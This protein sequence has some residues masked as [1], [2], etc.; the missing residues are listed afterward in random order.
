MKQ[1]IIIFPVSQEEQSNMQATCFL[2]SHEMLS[3]RMLK[4][5][6]QKSPWLAVLEKRTLRNRRNHF[7]QRNRDKHEDYFLCIVVKKI[8]NIKFII[9]SIFKCT[10]RW[11]KYI[12]TVVQQVCRTFS[13]CKTETQD[14]WNSVQS[15]AYFL[16]EF[17]LLLLTW[18]SSLYILDINSVIG[19]II[20]TLF[21]SLLFHSLDCFLWCTEDFKLDVSGRKL[22]MSKEGWPCR[23]GCA[24]WSLNPS[25]TCPEEIRDMLQK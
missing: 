4:S 14:P 1:Q 24:S 20:C 16:I 15:S 7:A 9:L 17:V 10:V 12:H 11:V 23:K 21:H 13:P 8:H 19:Y 25:Q 3:V 22:G 6:L 5:N 2:R 18:R